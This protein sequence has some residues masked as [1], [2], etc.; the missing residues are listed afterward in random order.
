MTDTARG[1]VLGFFEELMAGRLDEAFAR[2]A[3]DASWELIARQSDY[4][5]PSLYTRDSYRRLIEGSAATFPH[6]I[7]LTIRGM[8]CE[9]E[10]VAVEAETLGTTVDGKRYN[11]RYHFLFELREG[12]I[13]AA[14]EYLDS[15]YAAQVLRSSA[16]VPP[17]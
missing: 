6:G 14:R 16:A 17:G 2:V 1:T 9:G 7:A 12:R 3:S 10:R 8:T 13:T 5:Y 11:N 4:P 15:G